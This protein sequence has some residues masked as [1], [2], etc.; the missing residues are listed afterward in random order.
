MGYGWYVQGVDQIELDAIEDATKWWKGLAVHEMICV[1]HDC[2]SKPYLRKNKKK[3]KK[4][5]K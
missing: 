5:R 1:Y 2:K 3:D 4:V